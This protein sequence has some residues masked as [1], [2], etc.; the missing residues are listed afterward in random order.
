MAKRWRVWGVA[1]LA[2]VLASLVLAAGVSATTAPDITTNLKVTLTAKAVLFDPGKVRPDTDT[3]FV[4]KVINEAR[5]VRWFSLGGRKTPLL[6]QGKSQ[7]FYYSCSFA[8][9]IVWKS[10]GTGKLITGHF[11]VRPAPALGEASNG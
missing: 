7:L 10:G 2:L 8:G 4:I 9:P 1:A 5:V 3:T 11:T 6:A